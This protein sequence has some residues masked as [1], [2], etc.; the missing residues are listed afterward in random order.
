[1]NAANPIESTALED[2]AVRQ[3]LY[4][5]MA[6]SHLTP[7]WEVLHALVPQRPASPCVAA[8]WN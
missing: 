5:D 7:L 2:R 6:P 8:F 1:M 3:Q 4:A